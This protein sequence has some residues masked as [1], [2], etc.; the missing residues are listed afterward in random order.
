MECNGPNRWKGLGQ[1]EQHEIVGIV[2]DEIGLVVKVWMN[3]VIQDLDGRLFGVSFDSHHMIM[4]GLGVTV[5]GCQGHIGMNQSGATT[6]IPLDEK[7]KLVMRRVN[8][9]AIDNACLNGK[10]VAV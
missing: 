2:V 7:G 6:A 8:V 10:V 1:L 9:L 4:K 5:P 3:Q